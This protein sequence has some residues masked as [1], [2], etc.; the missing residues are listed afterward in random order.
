MKRP[1]RATHIIGLAAVV[2]GTIG[3]CGFDDTIREYLNAHFWLPFAKSAR[4]FARN[5]I[6]RANAPTRAWDRPRG[7]LP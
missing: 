3:A 6:R 4:H 1:I 7:N 2:C 5:G